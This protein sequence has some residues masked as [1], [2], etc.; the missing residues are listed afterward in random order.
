MATNLKQGSKSRQTRQFMENFQKINK[1]EYGKLLSE[2]RFKTFFHE[3]EFH[4]FLERQFEWLK[5]EYYLYKNEA[6]LPIAV[7]GKKLISLP[8]CEYGGPLRLGEIIGED[9]IKDIR[10]SPSCF[11]A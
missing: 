8:F 9:F 10:N 4:E 7:I 3:P 11:I 2:V 5:F 1:G 6:I